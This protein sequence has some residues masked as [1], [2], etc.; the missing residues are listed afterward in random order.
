MPLQQLRNVNFGLNRSNATGSLG[1]GYTLLDTTG[2]V[3]TPRTVD[4]VYQVEVGSGI[5]A[6][7]VTFPDNFRGQLL[8]DTGSMFPVKSYAA[9]HVNVEENNPLIAEIHQIVTQMS[10]VIEQIYQIQFGRWQIVNNQMI[11]YKDDNVTEIARFNLFD[12]RGIPSVDA[13]FQ[14]YKI[15]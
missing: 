5:Y 2:N 15:S 11:F 7:Y 9:E 4:G 1:V 3:I 13:V 8:W 6:A 14:R 10:S 12:D